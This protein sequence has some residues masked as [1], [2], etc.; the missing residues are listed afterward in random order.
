MVE[1]EIPNTEEK[2]QLLENEHLEI[3]DQAANRK[4]VVEHSTPESSSITPEQVGTERT[5]TDSTRNSREN[6]DLSLDSLHEN[7]TE[8]KEGN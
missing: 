1:D 3:M 8:I 7:D 2:I 6:L 5:N 4:A